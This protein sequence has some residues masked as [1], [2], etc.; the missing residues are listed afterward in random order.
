M[1]RQYKYFLLC[2]IISIFHFG[3]THTTSQ[4]KRNK[5]DLHL[6]LGVQFLHA[7][8]YPAAFRELSRAKE[9][10]PTNSVVYNLL[11]LTYS[12]R[13]R[14]KQA[15]AHFKKALQINS[16]YSEARN[17][18][19]RLY[20][21]LKRY[22]E[23]IQETHKALKD[24]KY[25]APEKSYTNLGLV[26]YRTNRL[27][28]AKRYFIQA[29]K[30]NRQ[31]C[32]AHNYYGKTLLKQKN[33]KQASRAFDRAIESCKDFDEPFYYSA[34]SH[35]YAGT[36]AKAKRR[37]QSLLTIYPQSKHRYKSQRYLKSFLTQRSPQ[38][39]R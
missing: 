3:C 35:F 39:K 23:A 22:P 9:L 30:L 24:L 11:A 13:G 2:L 18:L 27:D 37:F 5:T 20:I 7:K 4:T 33:F 34:L 25:Q 21:K 28:L 10:N 38:K 12:A 26:Y 15:E 31:Y 36:K 14:F 17:N 1:V 19:S 32:Q 8:N 6:R 29:I 16:N